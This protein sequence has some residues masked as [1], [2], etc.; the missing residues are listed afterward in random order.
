MQQSILRLELC[1]ASVTL[2]LVK[3]VWWEQDLNFNRIIYLKESTTV[4]SYIKLTS[5]R[6]LVFELNQIKLNLECSDPAQ[7]CWVDT[8]R[9]S[10]DLFYRGVHPF[11]V[12]K[13]IQWIQ[14][15]TFLLQDESI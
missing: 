6:H 8:T 9:N 5:K 3:A 10:V 7:G 1:A 11:Q 13:V 4:L 2:K 14:G 15:P 12:H